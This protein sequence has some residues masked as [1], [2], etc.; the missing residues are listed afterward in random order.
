VW[1]KLSFVNVFMLGLLCSKL[2]QLIG[3]VRCKEHAPQH[4]NFSSIPSEDQTGR[5]GKFD[6]I[7]LQLESTK[8][9]KTM[10]ATIY[11]DKSEIEWEV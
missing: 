1:L 7:I 11:V 4:I 10:Q 9:A 6:R 8:E 5:L 3:S 2:A